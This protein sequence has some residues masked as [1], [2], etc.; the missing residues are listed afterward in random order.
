MTIT[1][2]APT[3]LGYEIVCNN[4]TR[5]VGHQPCRMY[6]NSNC[7]G[8]GEQMPKRTGERSRADYFVKRRKSSS[9]TK[10]RK[11]TSGK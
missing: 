10:Q 9:N 6:R 2:D 7:R 8:G 5:C 4:F 1:K 11:A 3:F